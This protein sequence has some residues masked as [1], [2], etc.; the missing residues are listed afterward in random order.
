MEYIAD[1]VTLDA[2]VHEMIKVNSPNGVASLEIPSGTKVLTK[3]VKPLEYI[4][5]QESSE[6]S[7]P[8]PDAHIIGLVYNLLPEGATFN[9]A[10]PLSINYDPASLPEDA[11]AGNLSIA[12]YD[13]GR[14]WLKLESTVDAGNHM[15]KAKIEHF[16]EYAIVYG[17][18]TDGQNGGATGSSSPPA[19]VSW[20]IVTVIFIAVIAIMLR[21]VYLPSRKKSPDRQE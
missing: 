5:M 13:A 9:P 4:L 14:G 10:I 1:R 17:A 2:I 20:T 19:K 21:F 16:T 3:D 8:V 18:I 12:H 7:N 6:P 11:A 15:V